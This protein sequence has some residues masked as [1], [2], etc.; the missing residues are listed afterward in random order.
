MALDLDGFE[1]WR[2]IAK[3]PDL[4]APLRAEA[5]KSA[6]AAL[7]RLIKSKTMTLGDL[8]AIRKAIGKETFALVLDGMKDAEVKTLASRFDKHH[9]EMKSGNAAWRRQ[10]LIDL[11]RGEAEPV[12]KQVPAKR[13]AAKKAPRGKS[14]DTDDAPATSHGYVS[15]GV[16]RKR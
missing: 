14:K 5:A 4:F 2:A 6:R 3:E 16:V 13:S 15:A 11:I 7:V 1:T 12:A 8:K 10:H 9:P